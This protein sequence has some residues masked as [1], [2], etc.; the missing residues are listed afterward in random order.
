MLF[1]DSLVHFF[2]YP[3]RPQRAP[4]PPETASNGALKDPK[5]HSP[6]QQPSAPKRHPQNTTLKIPTPQTLPPLT[7]EP[8][9]PTVLTRGPLPRPKA[10]LLDGVIDSAESLI[11]RVV[12]HYTKQILQSVYKVVGSLDLIGNPASFFS[13]VGGGVKDFYYEP[14]KGLVK[15]P[16]AF[17]YGL[18][19]GTTSLLAGVFGGGAAGVLNAT[20]AG[21]KIIGHFASALTF[22][23]NYRRR[24]Q[25]LLQQHAGGTGQGLYLGLEALGDGIIEG[26]SGVFEQPVRGAMEDGAA[27]FARGVGRGLVGVV[28]KPIT[29]LAGLA[30]KA[31]EGLASDARMIAPGRR[32][33]QQ[34]L[35]LRMRQPRLI[36]PDNVLL[37]YPRNLPSLRI[38]LQPLIKQ[39]EPDQTKTVPQPIT[40]Q[41][42]HQ[43]WRRA[44][45]QEKEGMQEQ[46]GGGMA[47][48][49]V[50]TAKETASQE[51][52]QLRP[53]GSERGS[54]AHGHAV[55]E[56]QMRS[57]EELGHAPSPPLT[58]ADDEQRAGS[59]GSETVP[60]AQK[61]PDDR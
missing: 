40:V 26:V 31:T 58:R 35:L 4:K 51:G 13:D 48:R 34:Q 21:T 11:Q 41:K 49:D 55:G 46:A 60:H 30:S 14:R 37:A 20:S 33:L 28:T 19:S 12:W 32:S 52:T 44:A 45:E 2:R 23:P 39:R 59:P 18:A 8:G 24:R 50:E 56:E 54:G 53:E 17:T 29:G 27:G 36:G 43:A 7:L 6:S 61:H 25:L 9:R 42:F 22:D 15:S 1:G 16:S 10:L 3:K 5:G 47:S 57:P 38:D